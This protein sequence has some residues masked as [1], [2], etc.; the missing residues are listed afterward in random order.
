MNKQL[1]MGSRN[2]YAL[3]SAGEVAAAADV[4]RAAYEG[5][6]FALDPV[7]TAAACLAAAARHRH[8]GH[9]FTGYAKDGCKIEVLIEDKGDR[10]PGFDRNANRFEAFTT[11]IRVKF[12]DK[13]QGGGICENY[14]QV[15][16]FEAEA[17]GNV[18]AFRFENDLLVLEGMGVVFGALERV[19]A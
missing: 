2:I 3:A 18:D 14:V 4:I 12:A 13:R 17:S 11:Y 5:G 8:S 6:A 1:A 7:A 10:V 19:A 9:R 16:R 15:D